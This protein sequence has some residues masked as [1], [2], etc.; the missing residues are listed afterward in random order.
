[1]AWYFLLGTL[2]AFGGLCMLWCLF[3][4]LLPPGGEGV[5]ILPGYP[6][7]DGIGT[8]WRYL[9]LRELGLLRCGLVVEDF[10]LSARERAWLESRGIELREPGDL[11]PGT[12]IGAGKIDGTGNGD[13][14]G[15]HQRGGVPEL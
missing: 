10:G 1:M 4:W 14:S 2:A 15:H 12:G 9:W 13:P 11:L 7:R 3:G 8:V 6:E 5:L